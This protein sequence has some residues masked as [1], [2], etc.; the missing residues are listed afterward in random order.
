MSTENCPKCNGRGLIVIDCSTALS[1]ECT[2]K[3]R[4]YNL[5]KSSH[6]TTALRK[7]CFQNFSLEY[8]SKTETEK[9]HLITYHE[10]AVRSLEACKQFVRDYIYGKQPRGLYIFGQVGSGKTHLACSIANELIKKDVDVLFVVVP[11]YLEEIKYS[12][13][14]GSDFHEKEILDQAREV[15]VLIMDD[16]GVHSYSD[17][18]KSKIYSILNHRMNHCLPTVITSNIEY[19]EIGDYLDQRISSRIIE[20]CKPVALFV[21]DLDI[22]LLKSIQA[23]KK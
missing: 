21:K 5:A 17:W 16:L 15:S 9:D 4:D 14:Q 10:I 2:K 19:N 3:L 12:W 13:D 23:S 18:T 22:R 11:D 1:C 6:M 20:L 8:Y 7:K